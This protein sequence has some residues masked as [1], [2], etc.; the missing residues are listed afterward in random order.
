MV[1]DPYINPTGLAGLGAS[2]TL[3]EV[4]RAADFLSLH[5]PLSRETAGMLDAAHLALMQPT[6]YLINTARA[7]VV[8]EDALFD[9]LQNRRLA[10][11]ALD[12]FWQEPAIAPRWFTLDNVLLTPHLAGAADDVKV[13]H[14][15]MILEDLRAL[16]TGACPARIANP[17]VLSTTKLS[18]AD[19]Q[20]GK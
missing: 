18:A 5:L 1:F 11:A 9:A 19:K 4:L 3:D 17:Q 12:V 6:A 8:D 2:V 16:W 10:G 7:G 20:E 13:H 14:S 15:T